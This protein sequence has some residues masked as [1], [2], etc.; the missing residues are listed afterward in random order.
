MQKAGG[1]FW[2]LELGARIARLLKF[3]VCNSTSTGGPFCR[4]GKALVAVPVFNGRETK[5]RQ[6]VYSVS[7]LSQCA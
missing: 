3:T 7:Y 4:N 2:M 1:F 5:R 6:D